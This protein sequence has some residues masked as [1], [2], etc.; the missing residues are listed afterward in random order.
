MEDSLQL[1]IALFGSYSTSNYSIRP[2]FNLEDP[3]FPKKAVA[4]L[5]ASHYI[6]Q[7]QG[8][9]L[10]GGTPEGRVKALVTN[11]NMPEFEKNL[12]IDIKNMFD[13]YSIMNPAIK[14]GADTRYTLNH[15]RTTN[16]VKTVL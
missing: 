2:K 15:F 4:F 1:D 11:D 8:G 5:R 6:I 16:S 3:D 13:K 14:L 10:T 9:S 12:Y 7:R